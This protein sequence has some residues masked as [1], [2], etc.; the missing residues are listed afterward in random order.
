VSTRAR[1]DDSGSAVVEFVTVGV[2][3]LVPTLY[4]VLALG[5]LQAAVFAT[6]AASRGAV[7][8]IT[9]AD[10]EEEG[11]ATARAVVGYALADQGFDISPDDA[12][13]VACPGSGCLTPGGS[14]AVTV[15]VVV[16]LLG[17]PGAVPGVPVSA[18]HVGAVDE[19][20]EQP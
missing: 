13:A 7:R 4:L 3:L 20:R 17:L 16:P 10:S 8:A 14:V 9:S 11:R 5:R 2:L 19:F 6:E 12:T 15:E 18:T 1:G